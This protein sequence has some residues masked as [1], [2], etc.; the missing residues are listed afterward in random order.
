MSFKISALVYLFIYLFMAS[1][2]AYGSFHA[3]GQ[4]RA[5]AASLHRSHGHSGSELCLRP[6]QQLMAMLDP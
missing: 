2:A 4:I 6:T 5:A 1:P 3:R